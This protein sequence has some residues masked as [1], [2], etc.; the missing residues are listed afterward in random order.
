MMNRDELIAMAKALGWG[1]KNLQDDLPEGVM[2]K[3]C[4]FQVYNKFT[5]D[6]TVNSEDEAWDYIIGRIRGGVGPDDDDTLVITGKRG[7][8]LSEMMQYK[9]PSIDML[10]PHEVKGN[11]YALNERKQGMS[12]L[13]YTMTIG[14]EYA[15]IGPTGYP[16]GKWYPFSVPMESDDAIAR[17]RAMEQLYN[18]FQ[19]WKLEFVDTE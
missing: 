15:E 13:F 6:P 19:K 2:M 5:K 16:V 18:K 9:H 4:R 12:P 3:C 14:I 7:T 17:E 8:W 1:V 10:K 11:V